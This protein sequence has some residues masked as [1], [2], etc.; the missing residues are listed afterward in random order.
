MLDLW[1]HLSTAKSHFKNIDEDIEKILHKY[2]LSRNELETIR[3][4]LKELN[5]K[6]G[7]SE[8]ADAAKLNKHRQNIEDKRI[9]LEAE[10]SKLKEEL[11]QREAEY[12]KL[13]NQRKEKEIEEGIRDELSKR[14]TLTAE[15]HT[16]LLSVHREFTEEIRGLISK[17]ATGF[18]HELIDQESKKTL[19]QIIVDADYSIQVLDRWGKPFLANIS[20][21]QRQIMSIAFIAALAKAASHGE[22]FEMPLFMDTPFGRLS[23]GH[24]KNLLNHVAD[25]SS[26]WI[27]LATD[28]EFGRQEA[29]ILRQ[30]GQWGKFYI[31]KG[32]DAGA[33]QIEEINV[34]NVFAF[35]KDNTEV[36]Q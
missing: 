31:L 13:V 10:H 20:A 2:A 19:R 28:T 30:K 25:Y 23:S 6:I 15:T 8:R 36:P 12:T 32:Q 35:L 14:A 34:D 27:L 9:K 33:T 11:S 29:S 4:K 3:W 24:R 16:A 17:N 26:Q 21:G 5:N 1:R 18:F 7:S 22:I